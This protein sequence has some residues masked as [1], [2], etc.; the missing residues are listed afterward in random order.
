MKRRSW[1]L[2]LAAIVRS[3]TADSGF[4]MAGWSSATAR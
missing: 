4:K 2:G 1:P 3:G